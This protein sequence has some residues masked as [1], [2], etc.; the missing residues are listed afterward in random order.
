MG[1]AT[2]DG[3]GRP[4]FSIT[5]GSLVDFDVIEARIVELRSQGFK[6]KAVVV[7]DY[8]GNQLVASLVRKRFRAGVFKK[9]AFNSTAA[10]DDLSSRIPG[11]LLLHD[12]NPILTWNFGN[13]V[14]YR[15]TRG[16]IVPKK[17]DKDSDE[18]IDGFDAVMQG[19]AARLGIVQF[20]EVRGP[21]VYTSRTLIGFGEGG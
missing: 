10:T 21:H 20:E 13:V 8:Q 16:G 5:P 2:G 4:F 3:P 15:D 14:A 9:T 6:I 18:K 1:P 12:G 17:I 19:N 11:K 7:D